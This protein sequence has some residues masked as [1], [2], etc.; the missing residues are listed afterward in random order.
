MATSGQEKYPEPAE[1][2]WH[3]ISDPKTRRKLQ[4]RQNQRARR[5]RNIDRD[6]GPLVKQYIPGRKVGHFVYLPRSDSE[7]EQNEGSRP[8][9]HQAREASLVSSSAM[10]N[11]EDLLQRLAREDNKQVMKAIGPSL[12]AFGRMGGVD[13]HKYRTKD[14]WQRGYY[15]HS[16]RLLML[17]YYNVFR[18]FSW[19][20]QILG[21]DISQMSQEDYPSPFLSTHS[22]SENTAPMKLPKNLQPTE[23]QKKIYHHAGFDTFP[24][25]VIR[26]NMIQHKMTEEEEDELCL[27]MQGLNRTTGGIGNDPDAYSDLNE[28]HRS[29]IT[30]W[31]DPWNLESWEISEYIALKYP[32]LVRGAVEAQVYTNARRRAR[33]WKELSFA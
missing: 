23:V 30:I 12:L 16:D 28:G 1:E 20:V 11:I 17:L 9:L 25:P 27:D 26:N 7:G 29:G 14:Y 31:G 6:V 8:K 24:C 33:G 13:L 15:L 22:N 10:P 18:A 32:W 4:N 2:D 5:L 19:N 3:N 21:L